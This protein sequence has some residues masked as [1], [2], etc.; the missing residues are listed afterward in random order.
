M[1]FLLSFL[2]FRYALSSQYAELVISAETSLIG[3][4]FLCGLCGKGQFRA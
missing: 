4:C 2:L 1:R 3:A